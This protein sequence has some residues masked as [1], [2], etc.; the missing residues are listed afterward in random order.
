M[1][2]TFLTVSENLPECD[3]VSVQFAPYSFSPKGVAGNIL[4][5]FAKAIRNKTVQIM[6]HEIWIGDYS[7]APLKDKFWGWRQKREIIKFL[8]IV[9]P[10]VINGTNSAAIYR[11]EKEGFKM[12]YL[13][14]FGNIPFYSLKSDSKPNILR[15]AFF[16]TI[17]KTFPY[18]LLTAFFK[19]LQKIINN[20]RMQ[21]VII[22]R[23]RESNGIQKVKRL[24][25]SL[26]I[27]IVI[28]K[29]ITTNEISKHLQDCDIGISTTPYDIIGKSGATAAMLEHG[30]PVVTYDDGDTPMEKLSIPRQ[31]PRQIILLNDDLC[32]DKCQT[33]LKENKKEFFNGVE[34]TAENFIKRMRQTN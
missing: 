19:K 30:L 5:T 6:F 8:R 10:S 1:G 12:E 7:K 3:L 33:L 16:G 2:S 14:L 18:L 32:L 31:F 34:F 24:A 25:R 28:T 4:Q 13:Y 23:N 11:L 15:I 9:N 26:N 17:Y 29:E 27:E 21:L 22:G 20:K